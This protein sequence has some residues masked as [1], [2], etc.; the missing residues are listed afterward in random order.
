MSGEKMINPSMFVLRVVMGTIFIAHGA[1]KLFGMFGGIGIEGTA[2]L[3]EGLGLPYPETIAMV[4]ACVEFVGGFFLLFGILVR[5]A[6]LAIAIV[7]LGITFKINLPYGF[8]IQGGGIEYNLLI[9]GSCFP[10]IL[11]GGGSW[12]V[13]DA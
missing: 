1:Q 13:W 7:V 5:W 11:L 9:I 2:K 8:F 10:L 12:S 6:A 3:V 4:W